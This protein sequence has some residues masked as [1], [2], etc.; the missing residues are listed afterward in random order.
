MF[1]EFFVHGV[2][3]AGSIRGS[4]RWNDL[5]IYS[6]R[7]INFQLPCEYK[8][9]VI[10]VLHIKQLTHRVSS[11]SVGNS[12][13]ILSKEITQEFVISACDWF[14][15]F[16][17]NKTR[18]KNQTKKQTNRKKISNNTNRI[19][20]SCFHCIYDLHVCLSGQACA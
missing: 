11:A 13:E 8:Q 17:I 15:P 1:V 20:F 2:G 16:W 4:H 7:M 19:S 18:Q 9:S 5:Y 10:V 14:I 6:V 12:R 3:F